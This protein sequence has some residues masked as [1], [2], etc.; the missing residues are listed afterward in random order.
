MAKVFTLI[1]KDVKTKTVDSPIEA[2]R[3]GKRNYIAIY[4]LMSALNLKK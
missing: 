2:F 1:G 4:S 3:S